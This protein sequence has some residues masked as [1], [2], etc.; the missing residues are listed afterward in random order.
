MTETGVIHDVRGKLVIVIPEL[1]A[2]CFGCMNPE[3][4]KSGSISAENTRALPL[5]KGQKV[6]VEAGNLPILA[7]TLIAFLPPA[8]SFVIGFTLARLIF[9]WAP[10]GA[11]AGAG[12]IFLFAA[13][14]IIYRVKRKSPPGKIYTVTRIITPL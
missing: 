4:R 11:H 8:L 5:E 10:E 13:A 14:F 1:G 9:P 2:A 12:V 3:C 6:E 7:Q